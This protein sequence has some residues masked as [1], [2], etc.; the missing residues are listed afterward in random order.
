MITSLIQVLELSN[1]GQMTTPTVKFES[2]E[3]FNDDIID[4]NY[5]IITFISKYFN[6]R[7]S[8]VAIFVDIIKTV[9]MFIKIIFQD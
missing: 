7:R 1:V 2:R 6:L 4:R 8:R 9:T 3:I 5:D